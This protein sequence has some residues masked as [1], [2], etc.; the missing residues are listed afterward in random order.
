MFLWREEIEDINKNMTNEERTKIFDAIMENL[1]AIWNDSTDLSQYQEVKLL[2]IK[3]EVRRLKEALK[4]SPKAESCTCYPDMFLCE[5]K[6]CMTTLGEMM[7]QEQLECK[8]ECE[9]CI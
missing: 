8:K 3:D 1:D 4:E 6:K 7:G 9:A 2:D 5:C